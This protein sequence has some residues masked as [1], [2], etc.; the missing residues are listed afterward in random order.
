MYV[1]GLLVVVW[2]AGSAMGAGP[3]NILVSPSRRSRVLS[4]GPLTGVRDLR[5]TRT[6]KMGGEELLCPPYR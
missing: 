2:V 6:S 1:Y 4:P 5:S 3:H